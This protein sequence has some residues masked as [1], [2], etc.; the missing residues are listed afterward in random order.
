MDCS[1]GLC[2]QSN[3]LFFELQLD[4]S[5][6]HSKKTD[7]KTVLSQGR[8][9]SGVT[10]NSGPLYKISSRAPLLS[11]SYSSPPIHHLFPLRSFRLKFSCSCTNLL[12]IIEHKIQYCRA[13]Q[14]ILSGAQGPCI[15]DPLDPA[16]PIA[17]P[18]SRWWSS[19]TGLALLEIRLARQSARFVNESIA[20][21]FS[22]VSTISNTDLLPIF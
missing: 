14:W 2:Y 7:K 9:C 21:K 20:H 18:L 10:R 11:F 8:R 13:L 4:R 6:T 5:Q 1:V 16:H 22:Q 17:T 3:L 15:R 19:Y 12:H